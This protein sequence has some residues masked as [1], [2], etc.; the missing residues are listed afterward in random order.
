ML[1]PQRLG[2]LAPER[3]QAILARSR[4]DVSALVEEMP[5]SPYRS[6][7]AGLVREVNRVPGTTRR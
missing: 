1:E 5:E 3:R 6:Y 2:Q 7:V 4:Q